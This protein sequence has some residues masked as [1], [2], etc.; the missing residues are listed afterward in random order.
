MI[1]DFSMGDVLNGQKTPVP[2]WKIN[3]II[4]IISAVVVF[5]I[6]IIIIL[7]SKGSSSKN[8]EESDENQNLNKIGEINCVYEIHSISD[9]TPLLGD[10]FKKNSDL[11]IYINNKLIKFSKEYKFNESGKFNH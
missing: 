3:L 5:A 2:K 8:D 6:I 7:V 9:P 1:D 10:E 11:N 4:G